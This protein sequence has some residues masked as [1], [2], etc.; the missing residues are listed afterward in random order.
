IP[1]ECSKLVTLDLNYN[2]KLRTLDLGVTPNLESL[3][4]KNC[5]DP[6]VVSLSEL[7]LNVDADDADDTDIICGLRCLRKLT[8]KGGIPEAPKNLD[9]LDCLEE[10]ILSSKNIKNLPDSICML[11]HLKSLEIVSCHLLEKLPEDIGRL[12]CLEKLIVKDCI[13]LRDIP[14]SICEMDRLECLDLTGCFRI[15]ELP[16]VIGCLE[17]FKELDITGSGITCLPKSIYQLRGLRIIGDDN[18]DYIED[19]DEDDD[20]AVKVVRR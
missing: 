9:Q 16:E 12:Q 17:Y 7:H 5:Y 11:K 18:D 19:V 4:L 2:A 6:E 15:E 20:G 13:F 1:V 14:N 8:L 3:D 10:L